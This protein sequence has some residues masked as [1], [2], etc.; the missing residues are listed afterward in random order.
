MEAVR[1]WRISRRALV[2]LA[3]S[4]RPLLWNQA[5]DFFRQWA[6]P[7]SVLHEHVP[8]IWLEFDHVDSPVPEIP[9]PSFSFCLDPLYADRCSW[10]QYVSSRDPQKCRQV[11]EKGLQL[12]FGGPL[13]PPRK[14]AL[15]T[16][17]DSL[18]VGGRIIHIS[19]MVA[20]QPAVV[21][22]YGSV[23]KDQLLCISPR[24][25]GQ[26]PSLS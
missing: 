2:C 15:L 4:W 21:K 12:L 23:P 20:R 18:P 24:L 1:F 6:E 9:L 10:A 17:L 3:F 7:T 11:V 16:C 14:E 8:L 5:R 22:V 13:S 19:A 26:G 25:A